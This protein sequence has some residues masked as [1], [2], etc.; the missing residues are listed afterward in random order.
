[1]LRRDKKRESCLLALSGPLGRNRAYAVRTADGLRDAAIE[2]IAIYR[3]TN[4]NW[5]RHGDQPP[6]YFQSYENAELKFPSPPE[7][8]FQR[9]DAKILKVFCVVS[10]IV[11]AN[12]KP[13]RRRANDKH[14]SWVT[15]VK[16]GVYFSLSVS[17]RWWFS[18]SA[19]QGPVI[20]LLWSPQSWRLALAL[21]VM[22]A[23]FVPAERLLFR[24]R[25]R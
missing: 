13:S 11:N 15:L 14:P 21:V 22:L 8:T 25:V 2:L 12:S 17:T 4:R 7:W 23:V 16:S 18:L 1:M 9:S 5:R 10:A 3:R 19:V 24:C 20:A 6:A